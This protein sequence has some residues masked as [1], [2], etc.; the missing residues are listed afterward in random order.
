MTITRNAA[1]YGTS[2]LRDEHIALVGTH[3]Q[4]TSE[5]IR[6]Q[7]PS[8]GVTVLS[9][10]IEPLELV[11]HKFESFVELKR[12]V[13]SPGAVNLNRHMSPIVPNRTFSTHQE[14]GNFSN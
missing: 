14:N 1:L 3:H 9:V 10:C 13:Q 8:E 6:F 12:E 4:P 7:W 5:W 2:E 11:P